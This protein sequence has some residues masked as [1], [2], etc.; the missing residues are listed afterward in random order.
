MRVISIM[1]FCLALSAGCAS[2][3]WKEYPMKTLPDHSCLTEGEAGNDVYVWKCVDNK[4][5]VISQ[6]CAGIY[7]CRSPKKEEVACGTLSTLE[8][9]ILKQEPKYPKC[10][11]VPKQ[12]QVDN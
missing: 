10:K 7:P 11:N 1:I 4:R 9:D 2:A 12:W 3:P 5:V 8:Q 6:Y